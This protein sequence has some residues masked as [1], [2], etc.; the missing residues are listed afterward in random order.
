MMVAGLMLRGTTVAGAQ[1]NVSDNLVL[2]K[3]GTFKNT[4]S[5]YYGKDV[6]ISDFYIGKYLVTEK[7]WTE[8]MGDN[9]SK[10]T[11]DDLP[12]EMVTWYDA[13]EY[14]NRRSMKEG[15]EPYYNIDKT[16]KDP[17]NLPDPNLQQGDLDTVKWIVTINPNA[18]GY[19]LP[20]EAEWE[21]AAR[22]GST[23]ARY[24]PLDEIAWYSNNSG[25]RT[26]EVG[27]KRSNSFGLHDMLGNVWEW[28][29]DRS[30]EKYYKNSPGGDPPGPSSDQFRVLRGGSWS[31]HPPVV[32]VSNRLRGNP[33]VRDYNLGFRCVGEL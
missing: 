17:N 19:R 21:Y 16:R 13:I 2:V 31:S 29:D 1:A 33:G 18:N 12:V 14:C 8:V 20:T 30:D 15:L 26:Q 27:R 4:N 23:E 25:G 6:T 32:R 22:A 7:E 3:G 11:G 9:P 24:G 5:N 28:L 10:F